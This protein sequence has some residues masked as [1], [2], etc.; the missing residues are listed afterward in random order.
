MS[1]IEVTD[2]STLLEITA[3]IIQGSAI[4]PASF[5][6]NA[7]DLKAM[8]PGNGI[9]KYADE[10]YLIIPASNADSRAQLLNWIMLK[11]GLV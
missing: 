9:C 11:P 5:V 3:S 2:V 10:T 7:A 6:V 8:T 1:N 4:G